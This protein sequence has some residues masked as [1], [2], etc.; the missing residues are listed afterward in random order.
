[1]LDARSAYREMILQNTSVLVNKL[2]TSRYEPIMLFR[3]GLLRRSTFNRLARI[4][5]IF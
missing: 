2:K 1:M 3:E 4:V 5:S